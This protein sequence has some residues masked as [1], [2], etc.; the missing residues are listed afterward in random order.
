[1]SG[2]TQYPILLLC[3]LRFCDP[4]S[5]HNLKLT[6]KELDREIPIE[7]C[8][9]R[10]VVHDDTDEKRYP[11]LI[12]LYYIHSKRTLIS[13]HSFAYPS[14]HDVTLIQTDNLTQFYLDP[15]LNQIDSIFITLAPNLLTINIPPEY[16]NLK[17]LFIANCGISK[18]TLHP[19][20]TLLRLIVLVNMEQ[21]TTLMIPQSCD[22]VD[23]INISR[24]NI[25]TLFVY[26]KLKQ[27]LI[28]QAIG[29]VQ[30]IH[31]FTH[32]DNFEHILSPSL[33][34]LKPLIEH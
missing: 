26:P 27:P 10:L 19:T 31:L 6:C 17:A 1:M 33:I 29:I 11:F 4:K 18:L 34:F 32:P 3:F 15:H 9:N 16:T 5:I 14:I 28:I 22:K 24:S 30:N 13:I 12:H 8:L 7:W 23:F 25:T 21:L 2:F 20:W